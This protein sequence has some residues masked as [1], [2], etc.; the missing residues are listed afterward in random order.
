MTKRTTTQFP[1]W[2]AFEIV[3]LQ[4]RTMTWPATLR[5]AVIVPLL[6]AMASTACASD[7]ELRSVKKLLALEPQPDARP[8]LF[9]P[10]ASAPP[11]GI[12][13]ELEVNGV[14]YAARSG[15]RVVGVS[16]RFPSADLVLVVADVR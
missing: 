14:R 4:N 15:R 11:G 10:T 16:P 3:W 13:A 5:F 9:M 7:A 12:F 1:L 2:C 8:T 6:Q